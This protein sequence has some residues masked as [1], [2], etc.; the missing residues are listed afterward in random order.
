[1]AQMD[2]QEQEDD[3]DLRELKRKLAI[4][5]QLPHPEN[6]DEMIGFLMKRL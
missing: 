1:M 4:M 6:K 2:A 3:K 5:K